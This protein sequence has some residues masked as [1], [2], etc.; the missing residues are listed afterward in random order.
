MAGGEVRLPALVLYDSE[1]EYRHHFQRVYC[2]G[3]IVTFDGVSVR[4]RRRQFEHCFFESKGRDTT[5]DVFSKARA[6][7]VDW[8]RAVLKSPEPELYQGWDKSKRRYDQTRRV[9]VVPDER[10]VVVMCL[11]GPAVADFITAYVADS[12]KRGRLSTIQQIRRGP[13]WQKENR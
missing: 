3:T 10:Y 5:K 9:A 7:R 1:A 11:V 13:R 4:F 8:I 2:S 6:Q 12:P